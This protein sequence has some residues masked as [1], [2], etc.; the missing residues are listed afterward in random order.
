MEKY[1]LAIQVFLTGVVAW[2]SDKLGILF[3][4]LCVLSFLMVVDY[5][6]GMA[7]SKAEAIDHPDNPEYGW[8]SKKGLKGILKKFGYICIIAVAMVLDYII[9]T[10]GGKLGFE[11]HASAFFGL[12]ISIWYILNEL[13]SIT[14]NAGRMG[15]DVPEWLIKYIAVLK[16]KIDDSGENES[17]K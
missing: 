9:M 10:I 2:I 5:L 3:P 1:F 16:N 13:L 6:T 17:G 14:E 15:A 4:I 12:A 8:N 11:I 7:A